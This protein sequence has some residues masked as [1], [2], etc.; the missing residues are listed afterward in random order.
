MLEKFNSSGYAK[1]TGKA[2][3]AEKSDEVVVIC[4]IFVVCYVGLYQS[5]WDAG[6]EVE[7]E[8]GEYVLFNDFAAFAY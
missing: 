1:D 2:V 5:H 3:E 4:P 7:D 6:E 8:P